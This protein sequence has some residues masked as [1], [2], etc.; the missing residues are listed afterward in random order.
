MSIPSRILCRQWS[1]LRMLKQSFDTTEKFIP[2]SD[3]E[4]E[5]PALCA[6]GRGEI[7]PGVS[8][9]PLTGRV[10]AFTLSADFMI[11]KRAPLLTP[12]G[13]KGYSTEVYPTWPVTPDPQRPAVQ[14]HSWAHSGT[15][16]TT[17]SNIMR[18]SPAAARMATTSSAAPERGASAS[19]T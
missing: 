12:K 16:A 15:P 4:N 19:H 10:R 14:P 1:L 8:G 5:S 2:V 9:G 3:S 13:Q 18:S 7:V 6:P 11:R 17:C